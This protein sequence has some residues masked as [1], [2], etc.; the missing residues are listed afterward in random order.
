M[1]ALL[2]LSSTYALSC[3]PV[4]LLDIAPN[5]LY[6]AYYRYQHGQL[7]KPKPQNYDY[8]FLKRLSNGKWALH[9]HTPE[10]GFGTVERKG[11]AEYDSFSK[12]F[13]EEIY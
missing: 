10:R 12:G 7:A 1:T 9:Y 4:R 5:F 11:T 13:F 3:Y 2:A 6:C 8:C